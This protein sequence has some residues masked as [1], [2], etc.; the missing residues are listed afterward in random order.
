M[1]RLVLDGIGC[2]RD[3]MLKTITR[4][5]TNQGITYNAKKDP[6]MWPKWTPGKSRD[7]YPITSADLSKTNIDPFYIA[8]TLYIEYY[9]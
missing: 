5:G 8:T 2:S 9:I 6:P 4:K 3:F 7:S 1:I